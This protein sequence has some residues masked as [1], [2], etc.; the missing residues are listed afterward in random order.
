MYRSTRNFNKISLPNATSTDEAT[1]AANSM[2]IIMM[3]ANILSKATN[4]TSGTSDGKVALGSDHT[5]VE[6]PSKRIR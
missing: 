3:A 2:N 5:T 6:N 4:G 1:V